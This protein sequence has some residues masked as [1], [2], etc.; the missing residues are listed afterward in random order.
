MAK[1]AYTDPKNMRAATREL[2]DKI[3]EVVDDYTEQGY[4]LTLRQ[5][6]Y[7]LVSKNIIPNIDGQYGKLSGILKDARMCGM[8][9]WDVIEDRLRIPKIPSQWNSIQDLVNAAASQYRK[10]RHVNQ[11]NYVEV[12]VEKD[13]LS[14]VLEP[15][16][17]EYHLHLMVNRGYSSV[18]AMHDAAKRFESESDKNCFI[19]YLGDHDPSGLDMDRDIR[20]RL[21]EFGVDVDVE[22]IALTKEQIERYNPPPNPAKFKD[23]RSS[24]YIAEH[25]RVSWELDALQP[26]VLHQLLRDHIEDLIDMELYNEIKESEDI[27]REKLVD[28]AEKI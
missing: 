26:N 22:R 18:S 14:G 9:D 19:L 28:L 4:K 24:K 13:A 11:E 1:I 5:L 12:W 2:L 7:Q 10:D 15:I 16:T 17:R 3:V 27:E 21:A 20:D 23:P 6:Y 8:I 25:G